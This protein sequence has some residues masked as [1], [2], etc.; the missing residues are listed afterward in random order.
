MPRD[1]LNLDIETIN[2]ADTS[3]HLVCAAVYAR[4]LKRGGFHSCQLIFARTKV[5][6]GLTIPRAELTAAELNASTSHVVRMSL[7][8]YHKRSWHITDSQVVLHWLNSLKMFVRNCIVKIS[9]LTEISDW[10]F[11]E[12]ENM[13]ADLGTRKGAKIEDIIPN[14]S[15]DKGLPWMRGDEKNF[16]LKTVHD[17]VLSARDKNEASKENIM[18]EAHDLSLHT[19]RYVPQ[20]VEKRYNFRNTY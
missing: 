2:T 9:R 5:V 20:E 17:L 7:K 10:F 14:S 15:W 6:H 8:E 16:P 1:A 19:A 11:T 12:S 13:I 3:E 4:F 18:P